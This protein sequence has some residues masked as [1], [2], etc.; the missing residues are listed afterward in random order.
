MP[1]VV[2]TRPTVMWNQGSYRNLTAVFQTF[3]GQNYFLFQTFRGT[4]FIFMWTK[5]ITKLAFK[6]WNF[7]YNVF[8]HSKYQM[9]LKFFNSELQMP[10]VM[11]CKKTKAW[12]ISASVFS[13]STLQFSQIFLDFSI[14]MIIF[15]TFQRLENVYVKFQDFP[16]SSRIC[17]N[18]VGHAVFFPAKVLTIVSTHSA[19]T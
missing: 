4:L 17:T 16:Y 12:V 14:P 1:E 6:R 9:G 13:R 8:F 10:C 15:K 19:Y 18:S 2:E 11:N 3:P 7:L 5:N